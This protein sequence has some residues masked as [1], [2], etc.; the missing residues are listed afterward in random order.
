MNYLTLMLSGEAGAEL[1]AIVAVL[2]FF[3]VSAEDQFYGILSV[4]NALEWY[5]LTN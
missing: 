3:N 2:S 4:L 1:G 5:G